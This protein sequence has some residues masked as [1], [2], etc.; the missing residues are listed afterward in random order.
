MGGVIGVTISA[1]FLLLLAI[2]NTFILY[3]ILRKRRRARKGLEP[4]D[5][6]PTFGC[7]ARAVRPLLRL[8]DKP[9]KLYPIGILFSFGCKHACFRITG[10][11]LK[12]SHRSRHVF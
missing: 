5:P 11:L 2:I 6:N 3:R 8:I 1:S 12:H 4:E 10:M 7:I 9:W